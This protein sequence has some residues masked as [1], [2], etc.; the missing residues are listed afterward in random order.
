[1]LANYE[2]G[3]VDN[4]GVMLNQ[5]LHRI[6]ESGEWGGDFIYEHA[7]NSSYSGGRL[8]TKLFPR[9]GKFNQINDSTYGQESYA[10]E[11]ENGAK[12]HLKL[13][14][15]FSASPPPSGLW[16]KKKPYIY[17]R[18]PRDWSL[19]GADVWGMSYEMVWE[20]LQTY[21][22][23]NLLDLVLKDLQLSWRTAK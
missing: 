4:F 1:V 23:E 19:G 3:Q 14:A 21:G 20:A 22:Q 11:A 8:G 9:R 12:M 17:N 13:Q 18:K 6:A 7:P 5:H 10:S 16:V 15:R 2:R